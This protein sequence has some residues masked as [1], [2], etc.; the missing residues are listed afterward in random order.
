MSKTNSYGIDDSSKDKKPKWT[1]NCVNKRKLKFG[2]YKNC[3]EATQVE[4][5]LSCVRKYNWHN[6]S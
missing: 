1:K 6:K 4:N 3:L 5:K 2:N